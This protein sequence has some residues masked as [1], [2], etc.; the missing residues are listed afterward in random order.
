[1]SI[2]IA[3][4]NHPN[5]SVHS[6]G[7]QRGHFFVMRYSEAVLSACDPSAGKTAIPPRPIDLSQV[8]P[9]RSAPASRQVH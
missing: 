2:T 1:M 8:G 5:I 4:L 7:R 6:A 9:P 3:N